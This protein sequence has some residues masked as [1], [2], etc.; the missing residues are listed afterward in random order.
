MTSQTIVIGIILAVLVLGGAGYWYYVND[1]SYAHQFIGGESISNWD[2]Q[3]A[4]EGNAELE[5][6]AHNEIARLEGLIDNEEDDNT[7]YTVYISIANQYDLLGDGENEY[8][9]LKKALAIDPEHTGLAWH[10][11][12]ALMERLGAFQTARDA[13]SRA[14]QAQNQILQ[15]QMAYLIFLTNHFPE[16]APAIEGVLNEAKLV[17]GD[18]PTL[19]EIR[20]RWLEETGKIQEAIDMWKKIRSLSPQAAPVIDSEIQRLQGLL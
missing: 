3:G 6:K 17:Y 1:A 9:Y 18:N 16:D 13:Y 10:N 8:A 7:D 4:Y 15:Y 5:E 2:F 20:A 11:L 19:F 14:V 12:G